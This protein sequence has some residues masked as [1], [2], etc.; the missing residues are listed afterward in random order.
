MLTCE[1]WVRLGVDEA[2][3][4]KRVRGPAAKL[5]AETNRRGENTPLDRR[6]EWA[7]K[8]LLGIPLKLIAALDQDVSTV[9]R[10]AR[11]FV[12]SGLADIETKE[13]H[14]STGIYQEYPKCKYHRTEPARVVQDSAPSKAV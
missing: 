4:E 11:A 8:Y 9:G 5:R 12:R 7:A 13:A 2:I 6:C 14:W 3:V 10:V 1:S